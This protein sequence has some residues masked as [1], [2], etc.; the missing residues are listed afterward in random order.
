LWPITSNGEV[1]ASLRHRFEVRSI[2]E[3]FDGGGYPDGLAGEAIPLGA[4]VV[5][6]C[7]AFDAMT[8]N[9][10]YRRTMDETGALAEL[11]RHAGT[12]FDPDVVRA[13]CLA[14]E[15]ELVPAA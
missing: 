13:F 8:S 11:Q 2:H 3:R 6:V 10:P 7:D 5:A 12:Q 9:R 1:T 14:R 4:R 15:R